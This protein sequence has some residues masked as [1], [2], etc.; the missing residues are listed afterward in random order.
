MDPAPTALNENASL[1]RCYTYVTKF[2]ICFN[3]ILHRIFRTMGMR[4]MV[5]VDGE[6][7]VVG[8]ITRS[9][10]N[11]HNL[12]HFWIESVSSVSNYAPPFLNP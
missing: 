4:H 1:R 10:L 9:D 3:G 5:V 8:I 7:N 2:E 11:E 12:H 6:L